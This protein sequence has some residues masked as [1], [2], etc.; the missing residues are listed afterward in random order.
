MP[1]IAK[2]M[3]LITSYIVERTRK[4]RELMLIFGLASRLSW[5]LVALVPYFVPMQAQTVR[6]WSI[7]ILV[8]LLSCMGAFIDTSFTSLLCRCASA[9]GIS[10]RASA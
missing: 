10:P 7:L 4:R 6:I 9:G 1:Y 2:F 5:I 3:Q 8:L